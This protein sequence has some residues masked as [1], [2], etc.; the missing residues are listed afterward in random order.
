M[1]VREIIKTHVNSMEGSL[2]WQWNHVQSTGNIP[3][4]QKLAVDYKTFYINLC[5]L[6]RAHKNYD[7]NT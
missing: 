6:I 3:E 7:T 1:E 2:P 4:T 5:L